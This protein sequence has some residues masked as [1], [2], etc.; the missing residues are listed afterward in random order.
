MFKSGCMTFRTYFLADTGIEPF[1]SCTFA[2]GCMIV[3][4]EKG[5]HW[6]GSTQCLQKYAKLLKQVDVWIT[7]G[8]KITNA[9]PLTVHHS[10]TNTLP[11][12]PLYPFPIQNKQM[13]NTTLILKQNRRRQTPIT[14]IPTLQIRTTHNNTLVQLH[15]HKHTP[16]CHWFVDGS[17][18][19]GAS[20]GWTEGAT[21][22]PAGPDKRANQRKVSSLLKLI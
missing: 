14:T 3:S 18:G 21:S 22:R 11:S 13:S 10:E 16:K 17:R 6:T 4:H 19:G 1:R 8:E 2:G 5:D 20:A 9:I 7:Y 15:Q 12:N